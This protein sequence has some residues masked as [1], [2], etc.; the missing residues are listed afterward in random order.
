LT[1]TAIG[2]ANEAYSNAGDGYDRDGN[3]LRMPHLQAMQWNFEDQLQMTQRQA[4][5]A[6]DADG[7]AHQGERSYYVYDADGRRVRKVTELFTGVVKNERIYLGGFELYREPGADPLV[8]ETLHIM[9]DKQRVAIIE[10]RTH[11]NDPAPAQLVRHQLGNHL[12]SASLELDDVAQIIAYEEYTP[13]GS[14]SYQAVR[15]Q[16]ETP[17][18]YR[19]T[20][21]ERDEESGLCYHGARYYA[22]WLGRWTSAD[23]ATMRRGLDPPLGDPSDPEGDRAADESRRRIRDVGDKRGKEG[24]SR[25]RSGADHPGAFADGPNLYAYARC[26]PLKYADATGKAA[27]DAAS[28]PPP[29]G[30]APAG[31]REKPE[32]SEQGKRDTWWAQLFQGLAAILTF[33]ATIL[34][35]GLLGGPVGMAIAAFVGFGNVLLSAM[36]QDPSIRHSETYKDVLG[37]FSWFNPVALLSTAFGAVI[38]TINLAT[39]ILTLGLWDR[40]HF[41]IGFYHG[42]LL[43][44]GGAIRPG[45]AWTNGTIIQ[46]NPDDEGVSD[47]QTRE[48]ILR[49][50]WGHALNNAMFGIFQIEDPFVETFVG[51]Q[52][53]L[54]ERFAE[55]NINPNKALEGGFE[56]KDERRR[57]GGRGFGDVPWW[58]P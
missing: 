31:E 26:N 17:R 43:I 44:E 21:K 53:S 5:N 35:G 1:S 24:A 3:M 14:T 2:A 22:P 33:V 40:A 13:W 39:V 7:A 12:G 16:T 32:I 45:R 4:V 38:A 10:M 8:R 34:V 49:H 55:S 30:S 50:E 18:R 58:N 52:Y 25:K 41:S 36:G 29:P 48:L 47:P 57:E 27:S 28:T 46:V 56:R 6:S 23:P 42:M 11:G 20:G 37:F 51:Q 15:S 54:F 9:D 19:Y